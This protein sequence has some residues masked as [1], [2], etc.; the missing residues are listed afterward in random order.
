MDSHRAEGKKKNWPTEER[1]SEYSEKGSH[2]FFSYFIRVSS[3]GRIDQRGISAEGG[4]A[5]NSAAEIDI[6]HLSVKVGKV[7]KAKKETG[8]GRMRRPQS[9]TQGNVGLIPKTFES[10]RFCSRYIYWISRP[11]PNDFLSFEK[12][13]GREDKERKKLDIYKWNVG[14]WTSWRRTSKFIKLIFLKF[15]AIRNRRLKIRY[16]PLYY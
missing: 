14:N 11:F 9:C 7:S 8:N 1:I 6:I 15:S 2:F 16:F 13:D 4:S 12:Q 10:P 3:V 5:W